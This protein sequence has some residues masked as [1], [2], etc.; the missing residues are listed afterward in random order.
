MVSSTYDFRKTKEQPGKWTK[1][2]KLLTEEGE[3]RDRVK[4]LK[5]FQMASRGL[6][7]MLE[8]LNARVAAE[9]DSRRFERKR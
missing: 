1:P 2:E 6:L 9:K 3:I 7:G 4:N 5:G 8:D